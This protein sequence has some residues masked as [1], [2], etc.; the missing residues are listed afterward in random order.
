MLNHQHFREHVVRPTL[1]DLGLWSEAAE[2]LLVGTAAHESRLQ[3]LKQLGTGPALGLYQIEPATH[4]DLY[5]S[6]IDYRPQWR[7]KLLRLYGPAVGSDRA[8]I[9]H[10]GYAT[11]VARLLYYRKPEALPMADDLPGLAEYY[12]RHFNTSLGAG[13]PEQWLSHYPGE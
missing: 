12:K 5:A 11:A 2:N 9:E 10:M 7:Q 6:Y 3:W 1:H 4:G 13:T 8:L